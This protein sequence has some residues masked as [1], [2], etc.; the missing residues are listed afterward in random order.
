MNR[1]RLK[2]EGDYKTDGSEC[3]TLTCFLAMYKTYLSDTSQ[4]D[5]KQDVISHEN[6]R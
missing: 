4:C 6:Y 1:E 5:A 2:I 3:N